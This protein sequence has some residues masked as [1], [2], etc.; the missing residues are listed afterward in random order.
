M[1]DPMTC[2][3]TK[4]CVL[5]VFLEFYEVFSVCVSSLRLQVVWVVTLLSALVFNLDIGLGVAIA[6]SLLTVVF[7]TL[8][9]VCC[10]DLYLFFFVFFS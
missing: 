4:L 6:F 3:W 10:C 1:N 2:F 8:Q 9:C 7:R 5:M